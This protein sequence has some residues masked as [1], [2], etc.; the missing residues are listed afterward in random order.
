MLQ[1]AFFWHQHQPYYRNPLT[2]R[3]ALP[4]VRLHA[5]KDYTGMARLLAEFPAIRATI[6]F[7]PSLVE[8]ILRFA[9][10]GASDEW[11]EFMSPDAGTL[12]EADRTRLVA[13][14]FHANQ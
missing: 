1:L 11:L 6:N 4:W 13:G 3:S 5:T 10:D 7:V 8:Q 14:G 2:G 9:D 12:K